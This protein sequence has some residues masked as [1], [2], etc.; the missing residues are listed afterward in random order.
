MEKEIIAIIARILEVDVEEVEL[1]TAVGDL[2]EWDSLHHL[3]IIA[4]LE[5]TYSIKFS[6]DDLAELIEGKTFYSPWH[7]ARCLEGPRDPTRGRGNVR[8]LAYLAL[9]E[10]RQNFLNE[11]LDM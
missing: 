9:Q 11:K 3:Q 7:I 4:E 10:N 8:N 6:Q 5:K 1:D 2:P